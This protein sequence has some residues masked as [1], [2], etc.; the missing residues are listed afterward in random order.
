MEA[1]DIG[2]VESMTKTAASPFK[3]SLLKSLSGMKG[4]GL[5]GGYGQAMK[6]SKGFKGRITPGSFGPVSGPRGKLGMPPAEFQTGVQK[7]VSRA[8]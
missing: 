8:L 5:G 6:A 2:L 1:F 3:A 4:K 7:A